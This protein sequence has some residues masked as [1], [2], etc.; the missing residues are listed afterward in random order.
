MNS[1]RIA[2][3]GGRR[4]QWRSA[5]RESASI[6][7]SPTESQPRSAA[8][9]RL[10][11]PIARTL[12]LAFSLVLAACASRFPR[13]D[14]ALPPAPLNP[15]LHADVVTNGDVIEVGYFLVSKI[16]PQAYRLGVGDVLRVSVSE[17]AELDRD[18]VVVLPDGSVSMAL[19]GSFGAAGKTVVELARAFEGALAK[20]RLR[21]PKVVVAVVRGQQR[22]RL[23][24]QYLGA[25]RG[26][27]RLALT[28]FDRQPLELPMIA[29]VA[30]DRPLAELRDDI[31]SAYA[32]EFGEQLAVTVNLVKRAEPTLYV[33]GEVK[34]PGALG[35][36]RP[37]NLV[38]AIAMAG[39]FTDAADEAA[40]L[41]M[42]TRPDR[43]YDYWTFDLKQGLLSPERQGAFVL[44]SDDVVYVARSPI[45]DVNLFVRQYIRGL[46]PFDIGAGFSVQVR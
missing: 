31:R 37:V 12:I 14:A 10:A 19:I 27:N 21:E 20:A 18:E 7:S 39:G 5:G 44:R 42:R 9:R 45:A 25:D 29:S 43:D 4:W 17:H 15:A 38:A 41:V 8:F 40:I 32:R 28:V 35:L 6:G 36:V 13:P 26:S 2:T 22:L 30:V 1:T 33:M 24:M 46:L 23:F 11:Q 34:R 3:A 16:E